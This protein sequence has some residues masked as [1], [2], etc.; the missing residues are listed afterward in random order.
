MPSTLII[1]LMPCPRNSPLEQ[2]SWPTIFALT[3]LA[4]VPALWF[5]Y[6][7]DHVH[8]RGFQSVGLIRAVT[9]HIAPKRRLERPANVDHRAQYHCDH[10]AGPLILLFP[11]LCSTSTTNILGLFM[12]QSTLLVFQDPVLELFVVIEEVDGFLGA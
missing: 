6:F 4:W 8:S 3:K 7:W 12:V 11:L 1:I 5:R 2:A 10:L 9:T